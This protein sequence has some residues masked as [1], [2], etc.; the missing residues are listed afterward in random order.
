[1]ESKQCSQCG[2]FKILSEFN[3]DRSDKSGIRAQCKACQYAV[4]R[5]RYYAEYYKLQ[6]KEKAR[7]A[8]Q[9]GR[10]RK[11]LF[12][13]ICGKDKPLDRHHPDYKKPF[14]IIWV[15]RKCHKSLKIA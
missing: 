13:E 6:A 12:C 5:K 14:K 3:I 11:P 2:K 4:Q 7:W 9:K 1:M 8:Y 10:L 15:C